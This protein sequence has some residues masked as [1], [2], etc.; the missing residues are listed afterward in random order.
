MTSLKDMIVSLKF[1]FCPGCSFIV[2]QIL[3]P[4]ASRAWDLPNGVKL[5][6]GIFATHLP[7]VQGKCF[8]GQKQVADDAFEEKDLNYSQREFCNGNVSGQ[9]I[10]GHNGAQ[11]FSTQIMV[12]MLGLDIPGMGP[13]VYHPGYQL[14]P[15]TSGHEWSSTPLVFLHCRSQLNW[16]IL[17]LK[18]TLKV[19]LIIGQCLSAASLGVTVNSGLDGSDVGSLILA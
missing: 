3:W 5:S 12:E 13:S 4:S 7:K 9:F 18:L 2:E 10:G 11:D 15:P 1:N 6:D 19:G 17:D 8:D 16:I 14:W